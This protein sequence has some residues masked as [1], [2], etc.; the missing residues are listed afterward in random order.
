MAFNG[1]GTFVI[2]TSGQPVVTGTTISSTVF[3]ALTADIATGLST[4]VCKDGQT[5]PTANLPMGNY[6][7]TGASNATTA[8]QYLVYGQNITGASANF[9]GSANITGSANVSGSASITGN[10]TG[11]NLTTA[12]VVTAT[13]NLSGSNL[14]LTSGFINGVN[15]SAAGAMLTGNGT[16]LVGCQLNASAPFVLFNSTAN[17]A[18]PATAA[19]MTAALNITTTTGQ[20]TT[21]TYETANNTNGATLTGGTWDGINLNT[22]S[23]AAQLALNATTGNFT[24]NATG[25]YSMVGMAKLTQYFSLG[26]GFIIR[27]RLRNHTAGTDAVLGMSQRSDAVG[28]ATTAH[29][30]AHLPETAVNVTNTSHV[31]QL[32]AYSDT[33]PAFGSAVATGTNEVFAALTVRKIP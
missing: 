23:G 9:T 27:L 6:K 5:T 24:F 30:V 12:G 25:N 18:A 16:A 17:A 14:T 29:E 22:T 13:G 15:T 31:Y 8:G 7:H 19:E 26:G 33:T 28:S 21:L 1:A 2:D 32:Q 11:G 20:I 10:V 4:V 3:N